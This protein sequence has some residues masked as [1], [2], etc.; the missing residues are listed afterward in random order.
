[1]IKITQEFE[2]NGEARRALEYNELWSSLYEMDEWL[3]T[4]IK[5]GVDLTES[6]ED[7]LDIVRVRL[8]QIMEENGV[9]II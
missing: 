8:N 5:R 4:Q 1:M 7:L 9:N 6:E 2:T 3:R